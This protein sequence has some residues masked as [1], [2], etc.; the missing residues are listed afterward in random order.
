MTVI[1]T[2]VKSL[3]AADAI[4]GNNNRLSQ[5]M[6]RLSTGLRVNSAKDDAAGLSIGTKM[7]AQIRGLNM[8]IKNANDGASLLQTADD[9]MG[10][11]T[12]ALQRIRELAVQ[13]SNATN[14][15][16]DRGSLDAE[17]Q[18]LK[19][20]I[21]SIASKTQFNGINL[22]DGSFA[23]KKL[24]VGDKA[25]NLLN[26]S[27]GNISTA[28]L[29]T[30]APLA[31]GVVITGRLDSLDTTTGS[32]LVNGTA[33]NSISATSS[34]ADKNVLDLAD[35]V[36]AVNASN[37]G[38]T[39]TGFNEVVAEKVGTGVAA[40][41][42]VTITVT[43]LDDGADTLI[44][45]GATTSLQDMV[46]QIN[47]QGG[48]DTVMARINDE[49]KMVL[50]NNTG[51]TIALADAGA[52]VDSTGFG[53]GAADA[54][55]SYA[56]FVKIASTNGDVFSIEGEGDDAVA[57]LNLLG[58]NQITSDGVIKGGVLDTDAMD[59]LG[60]WPS[61]S[62]SIN[63]V[64]I[65]YHGIENDIY[66]ADLSSPAT[67]VNGLVNAINKFTAQTGVTTGLY[68]ISAT[69]HTFGL[70][71]KSADNSPVQ[72][73]LAGDLK[74]GA[75]PSPL[76]LMETNVGAA[77][78]DTNASGSF[79]AFAGGRAVGTIDVLSQNSALSSIA[80]IDGAL[81]KVSMQR[82]NLGALQNR[83]EAT[84]T[85]L[86]NVVTNTQASRS[87]I[88][89]ADY[90]TETTNLA[91]AQIIQQAATAML[92]QANQSSQTVLSLLK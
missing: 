77:D 89:D 16:Q 43:S 88:M 76:G 44:T 28:S 12:S 5:A 11:V 86:S 62:M 80:V 59:G 30:P 63:G 10:Q 48:P 87:R 83:I 51:A 69:D 32:I 3:V 92:A 56:G 49:G 34:A 57:D 53:V 58:L 64:D 18:Q 15:D 19:S 13:A 42:D 27:I 40:E 2:N 39:A 41:G 75:D 66:G 82:A 23:N 46:N 91:R 8:A 72:I 25:D 1:N 7:D 71:L 36:S 35:F 26:V 31:K 9:S 68:Q 79:G 73:K 60:T 17:V 45:L 67:D 55:S 6:Q 14:T 47:K 70:T 74:A 20:M 65:W 61:G 52:D 85:N 38:V 37:V 84:V 33:I 21:D 50:Y 24:L 29:G 78:F 4:N 22:L 54:A 81:N 90:A